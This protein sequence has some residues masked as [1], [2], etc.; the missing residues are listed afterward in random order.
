MKSAPPSDDKSRQDRRIAAVMLGAVLTLFV[1]VLTLTLT[2]EKPDYVLV[3]V[4]G[5]D[6]RR[7]FTDTEC[8]SIVSRAQALHEHTAPRFTDLNACALVYGVGRCATLGENAAVL[9][10]LAP[11]LA[12]IALTRDEDTI[13]P[14]HYGPLSESGTA[15]AATG[16]SVY[17][18]DRYVGRLAETSFGGAELP[19]LNGEDG[20]PLTAEALRRLG[21]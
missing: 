9:K 14:L 12:A 3:L 18:K 15:G 13:L 11:G 10:I 8:Q 16:R 21:G 17:F 20:Q 2:R 4:T 5:D 7:Q 19:V 1:V 6:C